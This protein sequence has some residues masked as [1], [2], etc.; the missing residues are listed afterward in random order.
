MNNKNNKIDIYNE[1]FESQIHESDLIIK[2]D[3]I[4][5]KSVKD[6]GVI[7]TPW[8]I[9]QEMVKIADPTV[10]MNIIEPSCGHGA[11]LIGLLY[12]MNEKYNLTG[13]ELYSWF[14]DKVVG[15]EISKNTVD[16]LKQ[17]LSAY[18]LKHF[19]LSIKPDNFLNIHC[20]DGLTFENNKK[21]DLCIGNPPYIRAKN[22]ESE[23]LQ[24]LK[25]SY[26]S[27]RKGT[28]DI[29]FAFIEKYSLSAE[30][31]VFITPNSFLTSKAGSVLKNSLI[32]KLTLLIDF[33]DKK[34]FKDASVYTCIFRTM[35]NG[36]SAELIY[37]NDLGKT[38][39]VK[40]SVLFE[41]TDE[42]D[43]LVDTVLSGIATLC[44]RDL[45]EN[46][47]DSPPSPLRSLPS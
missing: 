6:D 24:Y 26:D 12:Y 29:Y 5:E 19:N 2:L 8:N 3:N 43:G 20:H 21:I 41:Q 31:L 40:K 36:S 23:Y 4:Q 7:Y 35:A 38:N 22:L 9:V 34:V 32:D 10:D 27:C 46:P 14:M 44:A 47:L 1:Y 25:E 16:E 42:Q 37:G 17:I 33:K 18:F 11:F 28:I 13:K 30:S 45:R 15:V 39:L